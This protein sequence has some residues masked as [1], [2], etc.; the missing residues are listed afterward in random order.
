MPHAVG[1]WT[2]LQYSKLWHSS[3]IDD[4]RRTIVGA[5]GGHR[6]IRRA[7]EA[8]HSRPMAA[9]DSFSF[10]GARPMVRKVRDRFHVSAEVLIGPPRLRKGLAA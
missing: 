4:G 5:L 9:R 8:P 10:G 3:S 2:N 7:L 1:P 6:E